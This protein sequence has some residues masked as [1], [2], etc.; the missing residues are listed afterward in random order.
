MDENEILVT[1]EIKAEEPK[2]E[3]SFM[4]A[5]REEGENADSSII[6]NYDPYSRPFQGTYFEE[7]KKEKKMIS[8]QAFIITLIFFFVFT[9]AM[10]SLVTYFIFARS[11]GATI[12]VVTTTNYDLVKSTGS[13]LSIQ[14]IAAKNENSVVAITT[15]S[16]TTGS[17]Y[18]SY[19]MSGAGS[20]LVYKKDGYIITNHHVIDG[21][22]KIT[23]TL[24]NG[25]DY[26]AVLVASDAQTDVAVL[27]IDEDNL[28]PVTLGDSS[29]LCVGE[30]A[31]AIGNP[32]GTL[33]GTVSEG[34]VSGLERSITVDGKKMTL[35]Q[36]TAA[37][38]PG[39]SGGG[40]FN[41]SG[42]LIGMVVA[43]SSS[44]SSETT[45]EGIGFAIPVNKVIETADSLIEKGYVSGRPQ[46]GVIILDLTSVSNAWKYG[47]SYPGVYVQTVTGQN[48]EKAGLLP[49]DMIYK[50]DG[51]QVTS[52][53]MLIQVV[54]NKKVG[55]KVTLTIVRDSELDKMITIEVELEES[56]QQ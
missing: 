55:D 45:I 6:E 39:N 30:L 25:T 44:S 37:V 15:E 49:G 13:E 48:A 26:P 28:I 3:K 53:N 11:G 35:I 34:I 43:K 32:L 42:N 27:K 19:V 18:S 2:E 14:E 38:N 16:L 7:P 54:Q 10:S 56:A 50:I 23:V 22:Q 36:T 46:L 9:T 29:K 51:E 52:S 1:E 24:N 41:S 20:G 5:L 31:I 21:A 47:V 12:K 8:L 4:E 40:L 17:W 33:A